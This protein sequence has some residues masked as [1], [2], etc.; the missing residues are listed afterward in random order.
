M[1]IRKQTLKIHLDK[2]HPSLDYP[3]EILEKGKGR[4]KGKK[5]SA[6]VLSIDN[7][8]SILDAEELSHD[9]NLGNSDNNPS[10]SYDSSIFQENTYWKD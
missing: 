7:S 2:Y 5:R 8:E 4:G 1:K 3:Q 6:S 9:I 10:F